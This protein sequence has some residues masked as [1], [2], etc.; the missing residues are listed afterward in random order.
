MTEPHRLLIFGCGY[1]GEQVAHAWQARGN[2]V[3]AVTRSAARAE[4]WQ[5]HGWST[6]VADVGDPST[7]STLPA[8]D[9]VL[10]SIGYDRQGPYSQRAIYV[11]GMAAVLNAMQSR[12]RRFLYVSSSS[13]YG[14]QAGE[15]VDELSPC[16][17]TQPGGQLCLEAERLVHATFPTPGAAVVLRF[18]GI[19]GPGRLLSRIE[20]LRNGQPLTGRAD[21]WLNLIHR[22]DGVAAVIA[23]IEA[24]R[25]SPCYLVSDDEPVQRGDY[26]C[27]LA[28]MIGASTPTFDDTIAS[29]RGSGGLNKRCRNQRLHE[30]LIPK[31][32][33]PTFREGLA[34]AV[35]PS[36]GPTGHAFE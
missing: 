28:D 12:C 34:N 33:Y 26:Y 19:Y 14:Q 16:R 35:R 20:T 24:E 21:A 23:A 2:S 8:A 15:W 11:D 17:P 9:T 3:I 7:L 10:F 36:S 31:L 6:V 32:L 4:Q 18:A 22:D 1:L 27:T 13:V 30:E 25:V 29:P 5:Q